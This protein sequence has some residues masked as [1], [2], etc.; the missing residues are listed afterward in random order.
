MARRGRKSK[1]E[2]HVKPKLKL[3]QNWCKDGDI[4]EVICKKLGVGVSTFARYKDEFK[5]LREVL[6]NGKA[7]I[8]YMVENALLKRAL[9]SKTKELKKTIDAEGNEIITETVK[10]IVPDTTAQIFWLKNRK[11]E[12]WRDKKHIDHS[13]GVEIETTEKML[14]KEDVIKKALKAGLTMEQINEH[15]KNKKK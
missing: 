4:E 15:L 6:K 7:E 12:Q 2:T 5:E 14:S 11:P 1:W 13:G 3:I 9:G 8:D 10:E